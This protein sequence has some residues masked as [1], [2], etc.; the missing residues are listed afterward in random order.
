MYKNRS[1]YADL[2]KNGATHKSFEECWADFDS[3]G[4]GTRSRCTCKKGI[5][6]TPSIRQCVLQ[7]ICCLVQYTKSLS[8]L[9]T[10]PC[11]F[12]PI[13]KD[14]VVRAVSERETYTRGGTKFGRID[15]AYSRISVN[16]GILVAFSWLEDLRK[17]SAARS[18]TCL[19]P[20]NSAC[21]FPVS[22]SSILLLK[23]LRTATVVCNQPI[24]V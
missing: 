13:I 15:S 4:S 20:S 11:S 17:T 3:D 12:I 10:R 23:N 14:K 8:E 22:F 24:K 7:R 2:V 16:V 1:C 6:L 19:K 9:E 18:N 5:F 21:S